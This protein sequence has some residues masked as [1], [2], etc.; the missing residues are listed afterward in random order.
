MA[1]DSFRLVVSAAG[2]VDGGNPLLLL[3]YDRF[4]SVD[5]YK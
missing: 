5:I 3:K 1:V 2:L 4:Y